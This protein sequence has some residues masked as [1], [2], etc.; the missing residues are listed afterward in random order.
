[1]KTNLMMLRTLRRLIIGVGLSLICAAVIH[2]AVVQY[3]EAKAMERSI[4]ALG[5]AC[6]ER[7]GCAELPIAPFDI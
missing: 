7:G 5:R 4:D 3:Q 2:I 1:M 6:A